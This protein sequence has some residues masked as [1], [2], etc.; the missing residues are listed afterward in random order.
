MEPEKTYVGIDVSQESLDVYVLPQGFEIKQP[1]NEAGIQNLIEQLLP[2][3]V[4]M[5]VVEATGGLERAI[6][7]A[8]QAVAIPVAIVNPRQAKGFAIALGKA[9]TDPLDAYVLARFAQSVEVR[10]AAQISA[11]AQL[12]SDL[13]RRRGQLV[14]MQVAEKNRLSRANP[15]LH[16][17]IKEHIEQM[18]QRIKALN[19]Q[20]QALAQQQADWQRKNTLLQS[21]Q[22]IGKVTAAVCL[23]EL[24]ELGKLSDK[25]IARLVGVAPINHDSGKHKGKRMIC[26]GRT[27]V[28]CGLYM[29]TLVAVRHNPVLKAFY[30][31][32]LA[33]GKLKKV[34]LVACMRK[35]LVIINAM[36][37]DDK[38]WQAPA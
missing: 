10:P 38:T 17:D 4:T 31:R 15:T 5:V 14:E 30:D 24:P 6:V 11:Q 12:M 29:A 23:A 35:L 26:G 36:I 8:L 20:I 18:Q 33:K 21:V 34:A 37:R 9:K 32:L 7:Q 1:N 16:T 28:R 22:G 19:E 13:V 3:S 2:L 27:S 25:Q